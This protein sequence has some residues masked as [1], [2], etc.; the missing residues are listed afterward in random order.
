MVTRSGHFILPSFPPVIGCLSSGD[1]VLGDPGVAAQTDQPRS[2]LRD[3]LLLYAG[4]PIGSHRSCWDVITST[5]YAVHA[6]FLN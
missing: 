4:H 3:W 1:F 6:E 2:H 5:Q